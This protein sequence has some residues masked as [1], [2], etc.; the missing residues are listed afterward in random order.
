[1]SATPYEELTAIDERLEELIALE[2]TLEYRAGMRYLRLRR[3]MQFNAPQLILEKET[4][5]LESTITD[6][7]D[8]RDAMGKLTES[9]DALGFNTW[10][11]FHHAVFEAETKLGNEMEL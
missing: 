7:K 5:L 6:Y 8:C 10:E 9:R 4:Q 3:L 11:D 2:R 1:M